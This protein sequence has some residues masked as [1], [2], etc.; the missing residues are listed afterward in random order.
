MLPTTSVTI[1]VALACLGRALLSASVPTTIPF[2]FTIYLELHPASSF[3]SHS[4]PVVRPPF[5]PP[6]LSELHLVLNHSLQAA[7]VRA[8]MCFMSIV[9]LVVPT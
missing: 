4:S 1:T 7:V 3:F 6:S 9:L 2:H 8:S 5:L